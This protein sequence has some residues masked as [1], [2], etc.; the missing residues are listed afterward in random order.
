MEAQLKKGVLEM[1]VLFLIRGKEMYGY[2]VMKSMKRIF[3][4]VSESTF[5]AVL[6]RLYTAGNAEIRI[7]EGTGGPF[8]KYY[9]IT[10]DGQESLKKGIEGWKRLCGAVSDMG[11]E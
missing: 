9:K 2:D 3:P 5:Y 11:I 7:D 1:C 10:P 8:R 4:E 6:R